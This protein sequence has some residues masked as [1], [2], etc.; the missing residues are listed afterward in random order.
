MIKPHGLSIEI[1]K[2]KHGWYV[3]TGRQKLLH[4]SPSRHN[5]MYDRRWVIDY[6]DLGEYNHKDWKNIKYGKD[7]PYGFKF[8][9]GLGRWRWNHKKPFLGGLWK[10]FPP[11]PYFYISIHVRNFEFRFGFKTYEINKFTQGKPQK[12][13]PGYM[14]I[15]PR[16]VRWGS[17]KEAGNI[18][19][20]PASIKD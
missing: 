17:P 10:W 9:F 2:R 8:D 12:D 13:R 6:Y 19:V 7:I 15:Y 18:Y 4:N 16:F 3:Y 11:L 5:K 14:D 1:R 20:K